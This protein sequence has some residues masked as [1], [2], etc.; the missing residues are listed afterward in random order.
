MAAFPSMLDA[1]QLEARQ[2]PIEKQSSLHTAQQRFASLPP[3][4]EAVTMRYIKD[5]AKRQLSRKVQ[6]LSMSMLPPSKPATERY[7]KGKLTRQLSPKIHLGMTRSVQGKRGVASSTLAEGKLHQCSSP[8]RTLRRFLASAPAGSK[9]QHCAQP[10]ERVE[11]RKCPGNFYYYHPITGE[12]VT[13]IPWEKVE[14]RRSPGAFYYFNR[15]TG[16]SAVRMPEDL[17]GP[18]DQVKS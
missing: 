11:S 9:Y 12:S 10:W 6:Q 15:V 16:Q 8:S 1:S 7:I 2:T 18:W 3:P 17:A 4:G 13:G 5:K 14:S